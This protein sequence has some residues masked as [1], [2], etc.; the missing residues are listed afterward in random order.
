MKTKITFWIHFLE[1]KLSNVAF[2]FCIR[3]L[4]IGMRTSIVNIAKDKSQEKWSNFMIL[5]DF[6][7][8]KLL[9]HQILK[10]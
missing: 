3:Y 6:I 4:K 5:W 8:I 10:L 1:I 2:N 7:L 9:K